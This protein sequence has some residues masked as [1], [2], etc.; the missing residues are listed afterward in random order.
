MDDVGTERKDQKQRWKKAA[1][2]FVNQLSAN[3]TPLILTSNYDYESKIK[4]TKQEN[5]PDNYI[6]F[7][8]ALLERCVPNNGEQIH[9][10]RK[11]NM[12]KNIAEFEKLINN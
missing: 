3:R 2:E 10:R 8:I 1:Y 12:Q 7:T 4:L 6:K 11:E 9:Q 5:V